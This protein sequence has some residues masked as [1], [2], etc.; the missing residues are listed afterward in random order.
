MAVPHGPSKSLSSRSCPPPLES[1]R[2]ARPVSS[3]CSFSRCAA[4]SIRSR[5]SSRLSAT[6]RA[7]ACRRAIQ[8]SAQALPSNPRSKSSP[9]VATRTVADPVAR[10]QSCLPM[11]NQDKGGPPP[12][13]FVISVTGQCTSRTGECSIQTQEL[14]GRIMSSR[15]TSTSPGDKTSKSRGGKARATT[16]STLSAAKVISSPFKNEARRR[17]LCFSALCS[18]LISKGR[19]ETSADFFTPSFH[20]GI[21]IHPIIT[22]PGDSDPSGYH[23]FSVTAKMSASPSATS[24]PHDGS[25]SG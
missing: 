3:S 23:P 9:V 2:L 21:G 22:A 13:P 14:M 11:P 17:A 4:A 7:Q 16:A 15:C 8:C 25:S 10:T 12:S 1:L 18:S 20:P 5:C 19:K 24:I 6:P